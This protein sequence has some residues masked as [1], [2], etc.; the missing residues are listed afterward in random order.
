VGEPRG[1]GLPRRYGVFLAAVPLV[2]LLL[3]E[4]T[5]AARRSAPE[6]T[7]P[8]ATTAGARPH[9]ASRAIDSA[10]AARTAALRDLLAHRSH[11][12]LHHD[13]AEWLSTVDPRRTAFRRQQATAFDDMSAVP[14][15]SWRY[16]FDPEH[17][18][19]HYASVPHYRVPFWAPETFALHYQLRGFD[20]RPTNLPQY[21]TF[22]RRAGRWYLSSLTD[23]VAE[24]MRSSRELWDFGPVDVV[25]RPRVL[26]LGDPSMSATMQ[27]LAD[28]VTADIPRV[29][30]VWGTGWS[31]RVVLLVPQTQHELS[32]VVDDF[33]D[34]DHIAA[35]ATAEVESHSDKPN[36]VGDR[37]GINPANWP[38]LSPLGRQIV[39]THELT[40]VATRAVTGAA[41]PTWLAEGFADYVGYLGSDIPTSFAAQELAAE[42]RGGHVPR[43]FPPEDQ[44]NGASKRL[45]QAYEGA[46]LACRLIA[47]RY[48]QD[49]LVRFYR[50]V[51]TSRENS[52]VAV[53]EAT[54][55]VL[56]VPAG[57]LVREWRGFLRAELS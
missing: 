35:V 2:A 33:G 39:L 45:S 6:P 25:R 24:G 1:R 43:A 20:S 21:P 23:F 56:H 42:V 38:K 10:S 30:A 57:R 9:Q 36:P 19:L 8:P 12:V 47:T 29:T 28:E 3:A 31:R 32:Q 15:S 55:K 54:V 34:L 37:V 16:T 49:A 52:R 40:H 22:V 5:L 46:W 7:Q 51:G 18:Q 50:A 44:F 27:L 17:A 4:A 13:R 14:F 48:G 11:A 26:V 53:A 41:T